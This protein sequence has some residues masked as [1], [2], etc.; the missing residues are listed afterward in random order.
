MNK[1]SPHCAVVA[2]VVSNS[3]LDF[4]ATSTLELHHA[5]ERFMKRIEL[6]IEAHRGEVLS[7]GEHG[8]DAAFARCDDAILAA[9]EILER[10]KTLPAYR[11]N[12]FSV[13]LGLHYG[14]AM[15]SPD[16]SLRTAHQLAGFADLGAGYVS[17]PVVQELSGATRHWVRKL[18]D[19]VSQSVDFG[20]SVY[21]IDQ[22]MADR[23]Q[24]PADAA[25][26]KPSQA[27]KPPPALAQCLRMH[28]QGKVF[29]LDESRP[30]VLMGREF[31]ND[32]VV[33][34]ARTS[35]QHARIERRRGGFVLIDHSTN[36]TYITTSQSGEQCVKGDEAVLSGAG[37]LGCGFST[38]DTEQ[39]VILFEAL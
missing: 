31:G 14:D 8:I 30:V 27:A 37:R 16:Q 11:G 38:K 3:P 1:N 25:S 12:K 34:D 9:G 4:T 10:T 18:I 33:A 36:G 21:A 23:R 26:A 29:L 28:H 19:P 15:A 39:E 2:E 20:W 22:S 24:A 17:H 6:A 32:I 35:R 7:F 5:L 13:R